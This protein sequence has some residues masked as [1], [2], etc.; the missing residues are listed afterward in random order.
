MQSLVAAHP[1]IIAD[2]DGGLLLI[3]REQPIADTP[4]GGGRWSLDH[5]FVT[6][7]GIPVLV[8]LKRATDTRLRREVVGQILDY[9]ANGTSHW[10]AGKIA[11]EFSKWRL[12]QGKDADAELSEFIGADA[13]PNEFWKSVDS[14]FA[15]GRIKLVFVAD[16]IPRELARIIEFL[17]EQMK[18]DVRGVELNWF[19]SDGG[20]TALAPRVIGETERAQ[21]AKLARAGLTPLS[22]DEWLEK[23]FA[24][25]GNATMSAAQAYIRLI[26]ESGGVTQV[27]ST[28]GSLL[29]IYDVGIRPLYPI[30][31]V[32]QRKGAVQLCLGYITQRGPYASEDERRKLYELFEAAVGPLSTRNMSGYPSF[33]AAALNDGSTWARLK[34]LLTE[35]VQRVVE[36]ERIS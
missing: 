34:A 2:R 25:L 6:R 15:A 31:L 11:D 21:D 4:E 20:V 28:Q 12:A 35:I 19:E 10:Q 27:A 3:R 36:S 23:H 29:A 1:E 5:L 17:N 8:E 13:D 16:V 33:P 18:A 14:N 30:G 32:Y 24:P 9:A 26:E 22:T 7:T